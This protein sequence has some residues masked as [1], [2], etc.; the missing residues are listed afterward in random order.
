MTQRFTHIAYVA[1]ILISCFG[2]FVIGSYRVRYL[3][4][5]FDLVFAIA[6]E[7]KLRDSMVESVRS[8][9]AVRLR[10]A[11]L[12][13]SSMPNWLAIFR[14]GTVPRSAAKQQ[15][16]ALIIHD[17]LLKS[18]DED[19]PPQKIIAVLQRHLDKLSV[20]RESEHE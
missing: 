17:V 12:T 3:E 8:D 5:R 18:F 6:T 16:G 19:I 14:P 20:L 10:A 4:A 9:N 2:G 13:L 1:A 7:V 11:Y 15:E